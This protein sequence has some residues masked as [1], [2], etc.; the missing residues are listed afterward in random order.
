MRFTAKVVESA[1]KVTANIS[2]ALQTQVQSVFRKAKPKIQRDISKSFN[3]FG[4]D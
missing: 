2:K 1:R 4:E 3:S